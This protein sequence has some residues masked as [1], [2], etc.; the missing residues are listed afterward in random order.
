ME[1]NDNEEEETIDFELTD[2]KADLESNENDIDF[3]WS[4][5]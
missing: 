4:D 5:V 3:K 2:Q 1:E